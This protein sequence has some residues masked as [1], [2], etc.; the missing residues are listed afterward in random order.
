MERLSPLD[1]VRH[2]NLA[3]Q[4]KLARNG[5]LQERVALERV[6]GKNVWEALL[7]NPRLTIPEV[8]RIARKGTVPRPLLDL[9][10]DNAAWAK[11]ATV[12][13]ALL[14]NPRL[15]TEAIYRVL[16]L[17]PRR[18][19]GLIEKQTLYPTAVRQAARRLKR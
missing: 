3:E 14:S 10:A 6:F 19:L 4:R 15:G 7:H 11:S 9:I 5:Q 17:T 13:R 16:R 1:R 12:R 2:L 18:E 8:A